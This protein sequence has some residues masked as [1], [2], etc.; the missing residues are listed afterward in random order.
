MQPIFNFCPWIIVSTPQHKRKIP[1]NRH[2][3]LNRK[4]KVVEIEKE[5]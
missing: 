5:T 1:Y 2:N 4:F 3:R